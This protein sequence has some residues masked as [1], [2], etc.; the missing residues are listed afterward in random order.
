MLLRMYRLL[1][2]AIAVISFISTATYN[3]SFAVVITVIFSAISYFVAMVVLTLAFPDKYDRYKRGRGKVLISEKWIFPLDPLF[4]CATV[5]AV[6]WGSWFKMTSL[7]ALLFLYSYILLVSY[8]G[9]LRTSKIYPTLSQQLW[10]GWLKQ[11][12]MAKLFPDM[13]KKLEGLVSFDSLHKELLVILQELKEPS[14]SKNVSDIAELL[15]LLKS[16]FEKY[17]NEKKKKL[18]IYYTVKLIGAL[19]LHNETE[20]LNIR[21]EESISMM[22]NVKGFVKDINESFTII[23]QES[24]NS[25]LE[26]ADVD[27]VVLRAEMKMRGITK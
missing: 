15:I 1:L 2:V 27:I 8:L 18:V 13:E 3:F 10:G 21:S 25:Q 22:K 4:F 12:Q 23:L 14:F 24:Y 9:M 11:E 6:G 17:P 26:F 5:M 20:N 16:A 19:R 7:V